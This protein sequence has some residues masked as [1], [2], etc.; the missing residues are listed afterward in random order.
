MLNCL[1]Y[2]GVWADPLQE[3]IDMKLEIGDWCSSYW[4][5]EVRRKGGVDPQK[6][7]SFSFAD[8]LLVLRTLLV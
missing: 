6:I 1:S 5:L 2:F 8:D 7:Y 3:Q 4:G